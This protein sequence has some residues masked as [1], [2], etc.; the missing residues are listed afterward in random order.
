MIKAAL[1][2]R[3]THE[4]RLQQAVAADIEIAGVSEADIE[5]LDST[6]ETGAAASTVGAHLEQN[7][8]RV[9]GIDI[10]SVQGVS[11]RPLPDDI[12][13]GNLTEEDGSHSSDACGQWEPWLAM[14]LALRVFV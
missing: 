8:A 13:S 4:R 1:Q 2:R 10:G 14:V 3:L 7:L 9:E 12:T 11:M 6:F 5:L